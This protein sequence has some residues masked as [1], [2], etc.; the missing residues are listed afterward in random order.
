MIF[1]KRVRQFACLACG[2]VNLAETHPQFLIWRG[3]QQRLRVRKPNQLAPLLHLP[4]ATR[5][6]DAGG[7]AISGLC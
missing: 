7:G 3:H 4:T 6:K 1:A 5:V 2:I